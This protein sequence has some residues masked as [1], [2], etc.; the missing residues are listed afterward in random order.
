M[1]VRT[2]VTHSPFTGPAMPT[3]PARS[4]QAA[5]RASHAT[6]TP[7]ELAQTLVAHAVA[8]AYQNA[9][10]AVLTTPP[11]RPAPQNTPQPSAAGDSAVVA[12]DRLVAGFMAQ[13]MKKID[14][15][16]A[17]MRKHPNEVAAY[18]AARRAQLSMKR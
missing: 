18:N 14:A 6:M 15:L 16:G 4:H 17:V 8:V 1:T 7:Q 10:V 13:G 11:D 3:A 12:Y 2:F 9:V 5:P